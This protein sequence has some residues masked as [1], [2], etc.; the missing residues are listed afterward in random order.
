MFRLEKSSTEL[1]PALKTEL[2]P[3]LKQ[4]NLLNGLLRILKMHFLE[5]LGRETIRHPLLGLQLLTPFHTRK[6][7]LLSSGSVS[8][9][10]I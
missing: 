5:I 9:L 8:G 4:V 2:L 7:A 6:K 10:F 1:L 3:A